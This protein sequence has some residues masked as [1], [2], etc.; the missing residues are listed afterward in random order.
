M[1]KSRFK[2]GDLVMLSAAGNSRNHN[3]LARGGWGIITRIDEPLAHQHFE[4]PIVTEWYGCERTR[5]MNYKP[6]ELKKYKKNT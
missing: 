3:E 6:Y 2:V 1:K 4:F 5:T